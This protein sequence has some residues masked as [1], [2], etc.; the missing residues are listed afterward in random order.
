MACG[1]NTTVSQDA[2]NNPLTADGKVDS[3]Q[4][5]KIEFEVDTFDF[6]TIK[7]GEKVPFS[8]KFT[9]TG[10][11]DLIVTSVS[12]SCGCTTANYSK[13]PI[14]PGKSGAVDVIFDSANKKD[15]VL[16]SIVIQTNGIPNVAQVFFK[17]QINI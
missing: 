14:S 3:S 7:Q 2:I 15:R 4:L 6:G 10:K 12:P 16:K 17:G 9:N 11:T 5:A 13:D 1:Q 8:F